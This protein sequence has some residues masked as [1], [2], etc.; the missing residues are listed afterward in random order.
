M[1]QAKYTG[2]WRLVSYMAKCLHSCVVIELVVLSDWVVKSKFDNFYNYK[3]H[4]NTV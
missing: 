4:V 1:W 2:L 3:C